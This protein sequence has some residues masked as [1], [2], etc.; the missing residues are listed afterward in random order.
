MIGEPSAPSRANSLTPGADR[1]RLRKETRN[2]LGIDRLHIGERAVAQMG[3][4]L[5]RQS[6]RPCRLQFV[7]SSLLS[8]GSTGTRLGPH[9]VSRAP[10][11]DR[12]HD[13]L[14]LRPDEIDRKQT[15]GQIGA[16]DLHALGEQEAALELPRGDAAVQKLARLVLLLPAADRQLVLLDRHLDLVLREAGHRQVMRSFSGSAPDGGDS[17]DIV[18]RIAVRRRLR[19]PCRAR[20]RYRRS[21]AG[22]ENSTPSHAP[23]EA[24]FRRFTRPRPSPKKRPGRVAEFR[25]RPR[26]T[27]PPANGSI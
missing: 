27:R 20:A 5:R 25:R 17:L 9:P 4:F 10:K 13:P 22:T 6:Q 23:L 3:E 14:R 7:I 11:S 12:L 8:G 21:R 16:R 19:R 1:R 24:P 26:R 15:L 18:G 2:V